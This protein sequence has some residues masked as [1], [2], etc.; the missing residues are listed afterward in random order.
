MTHTHTN[1]LGMTPLDEGSAGRR[2]L[3]LTTDNT[4]YRQRVMVL[5]RIRTRNS[6]KGAAAERWP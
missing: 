3:Y 2:D 1:T 6:S 4:H 5:G